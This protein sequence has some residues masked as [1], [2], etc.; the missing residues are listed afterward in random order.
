MSNVDDQHLVHVFFL[1]LLSF[2]LAF[3]SLNMSH[4]I[5]AFVFQ[6]WTTI[7]DK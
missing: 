7:Y 3:V 4:W 6:V 2:D 1:F 5:L